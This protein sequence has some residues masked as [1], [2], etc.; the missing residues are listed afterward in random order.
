MPFV[1]YVIYILSDILFGVMIHN[2]DNNTLCMF[3]SLFS[4]L[5]FISIPGALIRLIK[6]TC[7]SGL[8]LLLY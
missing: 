1:V 6:G 8:G 3:W 5:V 4:V 2:Y 7:I